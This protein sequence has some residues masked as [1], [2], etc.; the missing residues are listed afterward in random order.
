MDQ[1][2]A[3]DWREVRRRR[4]WELKQQGWKQRDIAEALGV[5][6]GA[7][8]QWLSTARAEGV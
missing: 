4:A 5:T 3:E 6:E 2:K 8:S 7:V 1:H